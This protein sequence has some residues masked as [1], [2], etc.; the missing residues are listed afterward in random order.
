MQGERDWRI[1]IGGIH[2]RGD[3]K[4]AEPIDYKMVVVRPLHK[5]VR[6]SLKA[7]GFNEGHR[8]GNEKRERG[9]GNRSRLEFGEHGEAK[10]RGVNRLSVMQRMGRIEAWTAM[11]RD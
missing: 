2:S 5:R 11:G 8:K 7:K 3:R 10:H 9:L 4:S 6:K 1:K